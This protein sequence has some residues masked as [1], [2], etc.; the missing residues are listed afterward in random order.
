MRDSV[1]MRITQSSMESSSTSSSAMESPSQSSSSTT[2]SAAAAAG[3]SSLSSVVVDSLPPI[4]RRSNSKSSLWKNWKK[5][6]YTINIDKLVRMRLRWRTVAKV[7]G[8]ILFFKVGLSIL[9]SLVGT[10]P[11]DRYMGMPG[12]VPRS[13]PLGGVPG[14]GSDSRPPEATQPP[15]PPPP[16]PIPNEAIK[17]ENLRDYEHK[18]GEMPDDDRWQT[19]QLG[20]SFGYSAYFDDRLEGVVSVK[21]MALADEWLD[22]KPPLCQLWFPERVEPFALALNITNFPAQPTARYKAVMYTCRYTPSQPDMPQPV[23]VSL[24]SEA[25]S[26]PIG[27]FKLHT[28]DRST[29]TE[30]LP[31]FSVCLASPM[32]LNYSEPGEMVDWIEV[33]KLFGVSKYNMYVHDVANNVQP[34]LDYY[35]DR[36][37]MTTLQWKLPPEIRDPRE[38]VKAFG[39]LAMINDCL[40]RNM[41]KSKYLVYLDLDEMMV[42]RGTS[43]TLEEALVT[44]SCQDK[45]QTIIRSAFFRKQWTN[46]EKYAS[47]ERM[48]KRSLVSLLK[49]KR[50]RKV[51]AINVHAKYIVIPEK[52]EALETLAAFQFLATVA[53]A[54]GEAT[55]VLLAKECLLHHYRYYDEFYGDWMIDRKM[56]EFT[57]SIVERTGVVH[58]AVN[59]MISEQLAQQRAAAQDSPAAGEGGE[60]V[61]E[62]ADGAAG[63]AGDGPPPPVGGEMVGAAVGGDGGGIGQP[64]A[65]NPAGGNEVDS[66]AAGPLPAAEA[67]DVAPVESPAAVNESPV[68]MDGPPAAPGE[69]PAAPID[70]PAGSVESASAPEA[71]APEVAASEAAGNA[72]TAMNAVGEEGALPV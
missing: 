52:I 18:V 16:I 58:D 55:C 4:L 65:D 40:Y 56:H 50:E 29:P 42:P 5:Y 41:Y 24:S 22:A 47:D 72:D 10:E 71:A 54:T 23:A 13:E 7:L 20:I 67:G 1:Y 66:N 46:D 69:P 8:G 45:A 2:A 59:A 26:E 61:D 9:G 62:L 49:T 43:K 25:C 51:L 30:S 17:C 11:T 64:A 39:Q 70:P 28:F 48:V 57:K 38:S 34:F 35:G 60:A 33:H 31:K 53:N 21:V 68:E 36:G 12:E 15:P 32:R 14:N 19:I 6:R 27:M 44:T 63:G 3:S 37:E